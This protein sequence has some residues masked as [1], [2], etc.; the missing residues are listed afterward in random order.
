MA[1]LQEKGCVRAMRRCDGANVKVDANV[2]ANA[3]ANGVGWGF[4]QG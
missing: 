3:N 1:K 4:V 2:N